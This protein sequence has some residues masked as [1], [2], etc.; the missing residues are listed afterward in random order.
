MITTMILLL[1]L[2]LYS[3]HVNDDDD[4]EKDLLVPNNN[5]RKIQ[6]E[7]KI[8]IA[9][10]TLF[11]NHIGKQSSCNNYLRTN[12]EEPFGE[13]V[14]AMINS[15]LVIVNLENSITDSKILAPF[16]SDGYRSDP[17]VINFLK[18]HIHFV[19]MANDHICDFTKHGIIDTM[20]SLRMAGVK[21]AGVGSNIDVASKPVIM[22][23]NNDVTVAIF[24]ASDLLSDKTHH[25][26]MKQYLTTCSATA[27]KFGIWDLRTNDYQSML[28]S[29]KNRIEWF[30]SQVAHRI[31]L[32]REHVDLVIFCLHFQ[33]ESTTLIPDEH[34]QQFAKQF[35]DAGV[36]IF[37][38]SHPHHIQGIQLYNGRPIIYSTGEFVRSHPDKTS[39]SRQ[40]AYSITIREKVSSP[41]SSCNE[42]LQQQNTTTIT[43][44]LPA[45]IQIV[46]FLLDSQKCTNKLQKWNKVLEINQQMNT[47]TN[48]NGIEPTSTTASNYQL[49]E[50]QYSY[51]YDIFGSS[52]EQCVEND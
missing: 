41:S 6:K 22:S 17:N 23:L 48:T 46:P 1:L 7:Y 13:L 40:A 24:S 29:S 45:R 43:Q 20:N 47:V 5:N 32:I 9:G 3:Q 25:S 39:S 52:D 2:L 49:V 14:S 18:T 42:Q 21:F 33:S 30:H 8:F 28:Y 12:I 51:Y 34:I 19:S 16:R 44:W 50:K 27:S 15:D 10:D 31:A 36:D 26:T 11:A 35:I 4:S 38:G 37:V